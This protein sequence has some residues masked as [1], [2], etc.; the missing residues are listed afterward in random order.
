MKKTALLLITV[1]LTV[2]TLCSCKSKEYEPQKSSAL[3]ASEVMTFSLDGEKYSVKYELYRALF[4]NFKGEVDGGDS[5]VW[6]G[7]DKDKYI[8][9][10]D[11]KI[12]EKA[13]DIYSALALAKE[14]GYDTSSAAVDSE[15]KEIIAASIEDYGSDEAYRKALKSFNLN[16]S[17]ADLMYRYNLAL[18]AISRHYIGTVS[19]EDIE[20]GK[21]NPGAIKY[22]KENVEN[23]YFGE[24][25]VIVIRMQLQTSYDKN[26]ET[27]LEKAR[28]A[29]LAAV[30]KGK[31]AVVAAMI[32]AGAVTEAS[33][34]QNG[35]LFG[36][37][38]L[39]KGIYGEMTEAAFALGKDGVSE[40][41]KISDD[42]GDYHVIL[43]RLD[44]STEHFESNYSSIVY[45]YLENEV[46]GLL[47]AAADAMI[48][49]AVSTDF[50]DGLD[51]NTITME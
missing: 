4:L 18:T 13:A 23:F 14:I 46:G 36:R 29:L 24:E 37:H 48:S 31:D 49:S 33:E 22:T 9:K 26:P 2:F 32:G 30:P 5:T 17:V 40:A 3:E 19:A 6:N 34:L 39:D 41:I 45:T 43:Y 15:V 44:K 28:N 21:A 16:D 35:F 50:L 1:M 10:I 47:D 38:S 12:T 7:A 11:E 27:R 20:N 42:S 25:S 51:R 8:A